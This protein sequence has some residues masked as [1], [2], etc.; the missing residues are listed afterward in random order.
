MNGLV[1][2]KG[3]Y[4]RKISTS[5]DKSNFIY[6]RVKIL[7]FLFLDISHKGVTLLNEMQ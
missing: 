5:N 2:G 3:I 1:N 6:L 7:H 4:I